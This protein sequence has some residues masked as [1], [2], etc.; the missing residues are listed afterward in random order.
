MNTHPEQWQPFLLQHPRRT[1]G[2]GALLKGL[3]SVLILVVEENAVH[4]LSPPTIPAGTRDLNQR[5]L[6]YKSDSLPIKPRLP[7]ANNK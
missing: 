7:P 4:F 1:W 3:N 5:P 6:G 2:L